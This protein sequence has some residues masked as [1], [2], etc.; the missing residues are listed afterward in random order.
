MKMGLFTSR[1]EKERLSHV[2]TMLALALADGKLE[3][4]EIAAIATVASRENV[5]VKEVEKMLEG[6]DSVTFTIPKSDEE[7]AQQ[8]KDLVVL[9]MIDGTINEKE[10]ALCRAVAEN[11]G[12]RPEVVD[13]L[14]MS[15]VEE[16]KKN[17]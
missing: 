10:L 3:E 15:F 4:N 14:V 9:M 13:A 2:K 1:A 5:D 11:Y 6:K 17:S 16:I 12:Y 8:I 7:K